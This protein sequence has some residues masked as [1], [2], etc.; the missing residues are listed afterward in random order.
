MLESVERFLKLTSFAMSAFTMSGDIP[1][2]AFAIAGSAFAVG[3][4]AVCAVPAP[5]DASSTANPDTRYMRFIP[6]LL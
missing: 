5:V 1:A 6:D 3:N 4:P 2:I